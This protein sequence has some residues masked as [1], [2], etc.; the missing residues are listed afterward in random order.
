MTRSTGGSRDDPPP[1]RNATA[2]TDTPHADLLARHR[3]VHALVAGAVLRRAHRAGRGR[4]PPR[5]RRRGQPLPRLLRRHPHH[6]D[7]LRR[8]RGRRR[9]PHAGRPDDPHLDALPDR[10][11]WSSWPSGSPPLSGIPDA[12][13]FFTTSGTEANEAA[14]LLASTVPA[15]EPGAGA[16]QQLPRPLV[17]HDRH[18]R[19][20]GLVGVEPH[21][22]HGP[23]RRTTATASAA[24]SADLDRPTLHRRRVDD[25]RDVIATTTAGDVACLIAEPI[26][27]VG[28]FTMPP[29][30]L[31]GAMKKVLDEYGILFISDEVQTGWGRTGDHFWGY[32]AHGVMPDLLTFAKG[33]GNGLSMAG[34]IARG[35]LMDGLPANSISTFGGNPLVVGRRRSPTSTTCSTTTCRPTPGPQGD[36]ILDGL[37]PLADKLDVVGEV[38]GRGLMLGVE[39]VGSDGRTPA[40]AAASRRARAVPAAAGCWSARAACTAT[41]CASRRRCRSPATRRTRARASWSTCWPTVDAGS[42]TR[43]CRHDRVTHA[44]DRPLGRRQG[45]GG[46]R[47]AHRPR[48]RPG[49]RRGRR[50][51]PAGLDGRRATPPSPR[52]RPR[53]PSGATPRS[54]GAPQVLFAFRE[55]V[56]RPPRRA[57]RGHHRRAR[58]GARRRARRGRPRPRGRRVRL[59]HPGRC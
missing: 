42:T 58:Q 14:L 7:G 35:E 54:A 56:A 19:Q 22:V 28:G 16:A 32:Q 36:R 17:R 50:H 21:A 5:R 13:V 11:R 25:L 10:A 47:R 15:L 34:V 18:H 26:Q 45:L 38:R 43:R 49:H 37:A 41:A 59:R 9:H 44:R 6:D 40:P 46:R 1:E 52:P 39:L 30:G 12:K 3:R 8:A 24:R 55:L 48:L 53:P 2:V 31:F 51:G 4:G 57:G 27:G 33:L 20:P 23:L 29:D